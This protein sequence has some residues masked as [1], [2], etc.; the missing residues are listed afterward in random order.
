M[1]LLRQFLQ[2]FRW[3]KPIFGFLGLFIIIYHGIKRLLM[4]YRDKLYPKMRDYYASMLRFKS[5]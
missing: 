1:G 5:K 4:W 2:L 3:A